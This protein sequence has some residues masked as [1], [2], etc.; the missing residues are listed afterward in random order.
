[1]DKKVYSP[2]TKRDKAMIIATAVLCYLVVELVAFSEALGVGYVIAYIA[3]VGVTGFYLTDKEHK[4]SPFGVACGLLGVASAVPVM[5]YNDSITSML[6]PMLSIGL[7]IMFCLCFN[8]SSNVFGSYKIGFCAVKNVLLKPF[9][10]M[11]EIVGS[12]KAGDSK[13]KKSY[14]AVIGAL[15]AVPVLC[16]VVPLLVKSDAAFDG[17]VSNAFE[18]IGT[19]ASRLVLTLIFLPYGCAYL[20]AIR[21]N[22]AP[23][24]KEKIKHPSLNYSGCVSFLC[25]ISVTYLL[26]LFSQLAYFFSAFSFILPEDYSH[27]ASQFARRGFYEMCVVCAI[28]IAVVSI[29]TALVKKHKGCV[30]I[31]A[32][33]LF[34]SAF[35]VL[36]V[37]IAMQKMVLNISIY[38]LSKNRILVFAFMLMMLC[39]LTMLV[40]H[41]FIPKKPYMQAII[42]FCSALLIAISYSNVDARIA[43]YNINAYN[44]QS[45]DS[46]D[47]D[48][49]AYMSDSTVPYLIELADKDPE[50]ME[51][52]YYIAGN[53]FK[54]EL[55][56]EDNTITIKSTSKLKCKNLAHIKAANAIYDYYLNSLDEQQARVFANR[57]MLNNSFDYYYEDTTDEYVSFDDDS[58]Y[59]LN[60]QT[61]IYELK[62]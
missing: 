60:K 7:Y 22:V 33:S 13:D 55:V 49:I 35:S 39:V 47:V 12:I 4:P 19:V 17:L 3:L 50:I 34:I 45:I 43:E 23:K 8:T 40:M 20:F 27:T 57:C 42:I 44:S 62:G 28:N 16:A 15:L 31:K 30:A 51:K 11:P 52:L 58:R 32:L 9:K 48:S 56:I 21:K 6:M 18:N 1:M 53:N 24:A 14:S 25:V 29:V 54:D 41:I 38:G 26:Y 36:L 61:D 5:L 10:A 37:I 2:L 46:L 59:I